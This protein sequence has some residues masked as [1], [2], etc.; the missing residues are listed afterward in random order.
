VSLERNLDYEPDQAL[1]GGR[2]GDEVIQNLLDIVLQRRIGCFVCEMGYDQKSK[3]ERYLE[4]FRYRSLE[5][6]KDLAGFDRGF[7]LKGE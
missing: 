3:I 6:Y 4:G 2:E 5:F 1:F 7:T